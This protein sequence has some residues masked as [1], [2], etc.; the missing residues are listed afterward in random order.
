M[1]SPVSRQPVDRPAGLAHRKSPARRAR[2]G[3]G[4]RPAL[5]RAAWIAEARNELVAG[6]IAAVKVGQLASRLGVT[7]E[8][9]Y[10]HFK[11]LQDLQDALLAD[12][13]TDNTTRFEASLAAPGDPRHDL[14]SVA[15]LLLGDEP[16]RTG[17]DTAMRDWARISRKTAR[18]VAR[19]DERR[20]AMLERTFKAMGCDELE[21]RA[22]AR[23]YYLFQVGYYTTRIPDTREERQRLLP[24]YLRLLLDR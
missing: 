14:R 8:A 19:I 17:W 21:A 12:W 4:K 22:R 24:V 18:V 13:E 3:N 2:P 10:W 11:S 1:K 7:R 23:I 15:S 6:G 5:D 9:F 16:F 20:T